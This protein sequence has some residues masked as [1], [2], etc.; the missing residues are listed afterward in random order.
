MSESNGID[1]FLLTY[2]INKQ[3]FSGD[4][5]VSKLADALPDDLAALYVF[6]VQEFCSVMEGSFP[7]VAARKMIS[8]NGLFLQALSTK[9]GKRDVRFQTVAIT[10]VG[11]IGLLAISPYPLRFERIKYASSS[12]G[13]GYSSLKGAAGIRLTYLP[14]GA[15]LSQK[16]VELTFASAHLPAYEGEIYYRRR[17]EKLLSIIRSLDFSDG[18]ALLKP[19]NHTFFMGDLNYRTSKNYKFES[20]ASKSLFA[21]QDQSANHTETIEHLVRKYDELSIGK[22]SGDIF[23]GFS[24]G[25]ITFAPTYKFHVNTAIYNSKRSPSWCDR[26]LYQSTYEDEDLRE[27]LLLRKKE[28]VQRLPLVK[29]YSSIASL[30]QSDH[31]PVYLHIT[32]PLKPPQSLVAPSG[33]LQLL[34]SERPNRHML[35]DPTESTVAIELSDVE[36]SIS[37]PTQI[38]VK[39]TKIDTIIQNYVSPS[40]NF[41]I[42]YGLWIGTTPAGR[43]LVLF[44]TLLAWCIL[45]ISH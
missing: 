38:Y 9:Y 21:L 32:V 4:L 41:L 5:F 3:T 28:S 12:C 19:K 16:S 36:E 11:A 18:Y 30:L 44:I 24:E 43:L 27:G 31:H 15:K 14:P 2:N 40:S 7:D 29:K 22:G 26:I 37:G 23:A 1:L 8:L 42:G 35:H 34:P 45:Y 13:Y 39:P 20:E 17:N 6:G 33:Y 10:H 25:C